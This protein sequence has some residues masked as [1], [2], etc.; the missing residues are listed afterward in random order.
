M[1]L[2]VASPETQIFAGDVEQVTIPTAT[3]ELTLLPGHVPLTTVVSA[4]ILRCTP[5]Q[6][7]EDTGY[8]INQGQIHMG[9][10]TGLLFIDG[11]TIM[12]LTSLAITSV[13]ESE[14]VLLAMQAQLQ[15]DLAK[16]KDDDFPEDL[17]HTLKSL[18]KITAELRL[19]KLWHGS[20]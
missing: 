7:P 1:Y 15:A 9:I 13:S 4:G 8:V 12:V 11:K 18:E 20:H 6:L 2:K 3:G 16:I 14:E 19:S 5:S 17:E 10:S